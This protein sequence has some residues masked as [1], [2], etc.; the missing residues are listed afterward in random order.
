MYTVYVQNCPMRI[1]RLERSLNNLLHIVWI[2][3]C[4]VHYFMILYHMCMQMWDHNFAKLT[5]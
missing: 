4:V 3:V 2:L 5:M 1:E